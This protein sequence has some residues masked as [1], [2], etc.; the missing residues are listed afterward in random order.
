[1]GEPGLAE[2]FDDIVVGA[3]ILGLAHAFALVRRGRRVAVFERE[4]R[5]QGASLRNFGMIWPIGQPSGE[6]RGLALE[7]RRLW[8]EVLQE[9]ELWHDPCGSLHLA[10]ADDEAAVLE[11][12]AARERAT[13]GACQILGP[14]VIAAQIPYVR[15]EGLRLGMFS[16]TEVCVDP[17]EVIGRLA[18][19]LAERRGVHLRF[20]CAVTAVD[21]GVV[22]VGRSSFGAARVWLCPGT[23]R[24]V[25][26]SDVLSAAGLELCKL[27]MMRSEPLSGNRIGPM[28]A[29]GLT[30]RHYRAFEG[31]PSL[32]R[33]RE[34]VAHEQPPFDRFGIH[35]MLS[36]NG[37]GE[38]VIGDSHEYGNAIEPFDKTEIDTLV[39]DYLTRFFRPPLP[40]IASRW[41]GTYLKH[42]HKAWLVLRPK[43]SVVI[44]TGVGGAGMTL[45]FGLAERIVREEL[46]EP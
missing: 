38:L 21:S 28:L 42:P 33:L 11:E 15:P 10:Y 4:R 30:L 27:Q 12:F 24:G 37:R 31:L 7:S 39:L 35:V 1:L 17:R 26:F 29:G 14:T 20:D 43:P 32:V 2:S 45:S 6:L 40:R 16:P 41:H 19:W 25:L 36:Q 34:R 5:A 13:G 22:Q 8:L 3:G 18:V 44:V 46:G 9:T 23:E